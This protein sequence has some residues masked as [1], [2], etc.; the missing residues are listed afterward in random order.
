VTRVEFSGDGGKTWA[1]AK[2]LDRAVPLA[3]RLW[4]Y[5]WKVPAQAGRYTI[6]ARATD[7]PGRT[8][9]KER[10]GD[11]RNYAISHVLPIEVEVR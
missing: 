4:E 6:M 3:W 8:Q 7:K 9:P 2:L 11:L 5:E 10:S 1:D